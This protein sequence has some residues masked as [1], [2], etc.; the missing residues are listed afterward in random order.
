MEADLYPPSCPEKSE[1]LAAIGELPPFHDAFDIYAD[2]VQGN[3]A[4]LR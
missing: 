4:T 3:T 2:G 1:M